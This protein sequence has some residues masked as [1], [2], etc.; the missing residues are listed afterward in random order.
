MMVKKKKPMNLEMKEE[1]KKGSFGKV[2]AAVG[3]SDRWAARGNYNRF[4]KTQQLS[5]IGFGNNINQ[6]GVNWED[7]GEF[8]GQSSF[9]DYDNGDFGFNSNGQRFYIVGGDDDVTNNFDGRGFT[10]N[11]GGGSNYNFDNKK[12]K[13]NLSYFYNQTDLQLDQFGYRQT[14][15]PEGNFSNTDTTNQQEFRGN[16]SIITRFEK[17]LDSNNVL[18]VKANARLGKNNKDYR[19][20][21]LFFNTEDEAT[22]QLDLNNENRLDSWRLTSAAIYRH[23]FKK[24]GRSL[25]VSGGYN[26]NQSDG[27]EN[28]YSLNRFFEAQSFTD[29]IR[30]LNTNDNTTIQWK[31]S[32]SFHRAA[33]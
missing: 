28:S 25:A 3:S 6:T 8:K 23:R 15:L 18:I 4:N 9:G 12:A 11:F 20:S 10:K 19:Q 5:F 14:F 29:Q 27:T 22:N 13:F 24:K 21:Q 17:D 2:T 16:H 33:G 31:S 1:Y 26:G 7:Y 30:L 32:V